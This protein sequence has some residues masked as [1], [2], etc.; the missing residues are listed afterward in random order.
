MAIT[1]GRPINGITINP[2]EYILDCRGDV[3]EFTN[4]RKAIEFLENHGYSKEDMEYMV[5]G[6][7]KPI[8]QVGR[9]DKTK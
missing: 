8:R 6:K 9:S 7:V 2:L 3:M 5:F 4:K 1:V